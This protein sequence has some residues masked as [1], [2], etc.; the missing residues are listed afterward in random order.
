MPFTGGFA[1]GP[2]VTGGGDGGSTSTVTRLQRVWESLMSA[3]GSSYN[4]TI[5]S[6]IGI[7]MMAYA[8]AIVFDGYGQNARLAKANFP[9]TLTEDGN[10]ED[11][12][13][14]F[15][16]VPYATDTVSMRNAR[17]AAHWEIIG[18]GNGVQAIHDIA[19]SQLGT[20]FQFIQLQ[21]PS[22]SGY[23]STGAYWPNGNGISPN[24]VTPW[25]SNIS[26]IIIFVSF[27]MSLPG[28]QQ[29][30]DIVN[31]I[32]PVTQLLLELVPSHVTFTFA[33]VPSG[34][35]SGPTFFK[36]DDPHNLDFEVFGPP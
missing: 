1:P 8:R 22:L 7:E 25:Y 3:M 5:N 15:G 29:V 34:W 21:N 16:I 24:A 35:T 4:Q 11:W 36:L 20:R 13:E 19:V 32:S 23:T 17:V 14:S 27:D 30:A 18:S 33:V 31:A 10:L 28:A 26:H 2:L 12:E 6:A 9:Y